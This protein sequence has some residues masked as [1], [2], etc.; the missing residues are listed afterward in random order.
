MRYIISKFPLKRIANFNTE[1]LK[2]VIVFNPVVEKSTSSIID[3]FSLN[4]RLL[5]DADYDSV[6]LCCVVSFV[7][8]H[9]KFNHIP[10]S[11]FK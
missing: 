6:Y 1:Y 2:N 7:D 11:V 8:I 9:F 5:C 10:T 3:S 4:A